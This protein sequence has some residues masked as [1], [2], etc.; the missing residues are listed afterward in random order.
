MEHWD[1]VL[2]V[3]A[4]HF[5]WSGNAALLSTLFCLCFILQRPILVDILL[6]T[7]IWFLQRRR[8]GETQIPCT[9]DV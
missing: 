7:L 9:L 8:F 4:L 3:F 6:L 2:V 1:G 5:S